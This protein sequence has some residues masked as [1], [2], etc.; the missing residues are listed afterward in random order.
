MVNTDT[1]KQRRLDALFDRILGAVDHSAYLPFADVVPGDQ[2]AAMAQIQAC[3][4]QGDAAAAQAL[5][6]RLFAHGTIDRVMRCSALHVIAA[7]PTVQDM[8]LAARMVAEQ[9][10]AA[11]D[12]GGPRMGANLASVERHRGVLAFMAGQYEVALDYFSR[13]FER[14]HAPGNLANVMATLLRLGEEPEA[15]ELLGQVR[16]AF[17][18]D[19]VVA[20]NHMIEVDPDLATLR[21]EEHPC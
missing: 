14:Q 7:S 10:M 21:D 4:Q 18:R 3:L 5:V 15:R 8:G 13:A 11:L 6:E 1:T 19:L 17:P 9:E 12:L 2:Q 16:S 20:L